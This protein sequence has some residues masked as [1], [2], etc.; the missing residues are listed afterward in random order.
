MVNFKKTH[1]ITNEQNFRSLIGYAG[2]E[3]AIS[4]LMM[5]GFNVLRSLWRDSKYD[6]MFEANNAS[7]KIEIKQTTKEKFTV[8]SGS[9]SGQQISR[10]AE[11]REAILK[12][13]DADFFF[14]V[15]TVDA[16][17]WMMPVELIEI[18]KRKSFDFKHIK[19]FKEKFKIFLGF[20]DLDLT[21][22][23]IQ[24]GFMNWNL[25]ELETFCQKNKIKISN[26][27][28]KGRFNYPKRKLLG[29][30]SDRLESII[31]NYKNS[32]IL[33]I[34]IFLFTKVKN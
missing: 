4:R 19:I 11:N 31:V 25:S 27:N 24:E 2:Q 12:K 10:S 18:C 21:S 7:I 32:L 28:K 26:Q 22:K 5:C 29:A 6:G 3:L 17:C 14:G 30:N 1:N 8:T 9:R 33:D 20:P 15:S 16:T 34:W 13:E 23:D